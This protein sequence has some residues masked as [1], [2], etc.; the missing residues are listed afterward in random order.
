MLFMYRS[1]KYLNNVSYTL[2][3]HGHTPR[4]GENV[5]HTHDTPT[6][7]ANEHWG[8]KCQT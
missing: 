8:R 5:R 1:L 2:A 6:P 3:I 4:K 7:H